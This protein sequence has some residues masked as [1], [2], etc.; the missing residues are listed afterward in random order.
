MKTCDTKHMKDV[1][2]DKINVCKRVKN[3][4][5]TQQMLM[6]FVTI[7]IS[8]HSSKILDLTPKTFFDTS[9][10]THTEHTQ[11]YMADTQNIN[12]LMRLLFQSSSSQRASTFMFCKKGFYSASY[13]WTSQRPPY[14]RGCFRLPMSNHNWNR[15]EQDKVN[16]CQFC[17]M[18]C[19]ILLKSCREFCNGNLKCW[20]KGWWYIE[21]WWNLF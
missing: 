9:T 1:Y 3:I 18:S 13:F 20:V 17:L 7:P 21:I 5:A 4:E 19:C 15:S 6:H 2:E 8:A 12:F 16:I 10:N 14:I 11:T